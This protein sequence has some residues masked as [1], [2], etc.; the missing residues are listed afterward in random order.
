MHPAI[1]VEGVSKSYKI[2]EFS[3]DS[4]I[5]DF[6][7]N[8]N[9]VKNFIN[10]SDV[11]DIKHHD[12]LLWSLKDI[13]FSIERGETF[14]IIGKNGAGKS[15]LLK[16]LSQITSPTTGSVKLKGKIASLLEVGTGFH[17]DLTGR[18]NIFLNGAILGMRKTEIQ[19]NFDEIVEFSGVSKFIDTPVKRYSSGMYVRL[20]FAVAAHLNSDVLI[21]DEVLAVGDGE[22]QKKCLGKM[23]E[24][25]NSSGKTILFVSHNL[26]AVRHL[27]KRSILLDKGRLV[28]DSST[29]NVIA[30][31]LNYSEAKTFEKNLEERDFENDWFKLTNIRLKDASGNTISVYNISEEY[32]IE[33]AYV[34]KKESRLKF[35]MTISTDDGITIFSSLNNLD[36]EFYEKQHQ[37]GEYRSTVKIHSDFFNE[38]SFSISLAS[39]V[40][41]NDNFSFQNIISFNTTDDGKLK[42]DYFGGYGG[43][44]RPRLTWESQKMK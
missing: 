1:L 33:F 5:S 22:F 20:A 32:F 15:T 21:V 26:H 16:I 18:E 11:E 35:S 41:F 25:S 31:Y 36:L 43:F 24:V 4:L 40:E 6:K 13:S 12:T 3:S 17:P 29:S 10:K 42:R 8:I 39:Y 7:K 27:C 44:L 38:G 37:P 14:G 28:L 9:K 23:N 2:G 19:R 34:V 30:E